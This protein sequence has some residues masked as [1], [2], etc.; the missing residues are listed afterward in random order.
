M[1]ETNDRNH[2]SNRGDVILGP[3]EGQD[4]LVLGPYLGEF[5]W[6]MFSW[7]PMMR[8]VALLHPDRYVIAFTRGGE[9]KKKLYSFADEVR[10]PIDDPGFP[11]ECLLW[12]DFDKAKQEAANVVIKACLD[13]VMQ[14][15]GK[16]GDRD[17]S[18]EVA[19]Y[20]NLK[21]FN[22]PAFARGCPDPLIG[23][24]ALACDQYDLDPAEKLVALCVRDRSVSR[25][26]NWGAEN[27]STLGGCLQDKGIK[28]VFVGRIENR[29]EW[30]SLFSVIVGECDLTDMTSVDDLINLFA[31]A[32]L[33]VGGST[34]T[35][36]LAS[37]CACPHLVWG[38]EKNVMR[39]AETNWFGANHKVYE[40]GWEP[41]PVSVAE[42][43]E[44]YLTE[45]SFL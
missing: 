17:R 44:H 27:W 29:E 21:S 34:G 43:I 2:K 5:G 14:E 1:G 26:R 32:A 11:S 9:G 31:G 22:D 16:D 45:G 40:W 24:Y 39:F 20:G 23:D 35:L 12:H 6:E 19:S 8:A 13:S 4:I 42:S 7:Q 36:H 30:E 41:E 37:R 38:G 28:H 15:Y 3:I 33:A 18:I 10:E 25:F